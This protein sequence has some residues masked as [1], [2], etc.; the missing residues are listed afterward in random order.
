[1]SGK[2][3]LQL[4]MSTCRQSVR[5]SDKMESLPLKS[6]DVSLGKA[7]PPDSEWGPDTGI[8]SGSDVAPTQL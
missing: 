8:T 7:V 4:V 3:V 2:F 6:K 1:M 5:V